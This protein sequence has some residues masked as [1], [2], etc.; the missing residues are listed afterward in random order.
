MTQDKPGTKHKCVFPSWRSL[1]LNSAGAFLTDGNVSGR[2]EE[3]VEHDGVEGRVEAVD[4]RHRGQHGVGQTCGAQR[5]GGVNK[6]NRPKGPEVAS[7]ARA[8]RWDTT[9]RRRRSSGEELHGSWRRPDPD[10]SLRWP[11]SARRS[12]SPRRWELRV[13]PF[14]RIETR[15]HD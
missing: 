5:R 1:R 6:Q 10:S 12:A 8:C 13:K 11:H 9:T 4:W 7:R 3:G 15:V 2:A 14:H